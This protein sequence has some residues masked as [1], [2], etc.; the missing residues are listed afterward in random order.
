MFA[1]FATTVAL[2]Q[3]DLFTTLQHLYVLSQFHSFHSLSV[4]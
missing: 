4:G 3:A 1:S 2:N